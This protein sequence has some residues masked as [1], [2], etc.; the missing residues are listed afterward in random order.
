MSSCC[1]PEKAT[2]LSTTWFFICVQGNAVTH[3]AWGSHS[4]EGG[5]LQERSRTVKCSVSTKQPHCAAQ[6]KGPRAAQT[7]KQNYSGALPHC[8]HS[9]QGHT[10]SEPTPK[11]PRIRSLG[12]KSHFYQL[13]LKIMTRNKVQEEQEQ[14]LSSSSRCPG[15]AGRAAFQRWAFL[16]M[17]NNQSS[18]CRAGELFLQSE[19]LMWNPEPSAG[20]VPAPGADSH[21]GALQSSPPSPWRCS[22]LWGHSCACNTSV[23]LGEPGPWNSLLPS[24]LHP[25]GHGL[26]LHPPILCALVSFKKFQGRRGVSYRLLTL[27]VPTN[28]LL[29]VYSV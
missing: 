3:W 13:I 4:S 28:I 17:F 21:Q 26:P 6:V 16:A 18:L 23:K 19:G 22:E 15:G 7:P 12:V 11:L 27:P 5:N 10:C 24:L 20:S 8:Q 2:H 9:M 25:Q 29:L 14:T 1:L